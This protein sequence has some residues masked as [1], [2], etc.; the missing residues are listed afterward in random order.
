MYKDSP[1]KILILSEKLNQFESL[2]FYR[3]KYPSQFC[4]PVDLNSGG[5][6][7]FRYVWPPVSAGGRTVCGPPTK[8]TR[9]YVADSRRQT[10]IRQ[11]SGKLSP[12]LSKK[13][14]EN[15]KCLLDH[16]GEHKNQIRR[17]I[18]SCSQG[19]SVRNQFDYL[20]GIKR[21]E[22]PWKTKHFVFLCG[23]SENQYRKNPGMR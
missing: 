20:F 23:S 14:G 1:A 17:E 10:R 4:L 16:L 19:L 5:F 18:I 11:D 6:F 13:G 22:V 3:A 15:G 8:C 7:F 2:S 9:H 21:F 12:A